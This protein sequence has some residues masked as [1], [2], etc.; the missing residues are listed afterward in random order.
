[1][2][3]QAMAAGASVLVLVVAGC[4]S[5]GG[6][7]ATGEAGANRAQDAS[8]AFARCMREHGVDMPDPRANGQSGDFSFQVPRNSKGNPSFERAQAACQHLMDRAVKAAGPAPDR[9]R[10]LNAALAYARCMRQHGLD[11]PDPKADPNGMVKIGG[12]G[13]N[14][15]D[16]AF[17]RADA[18]C[19][20]L[21]PGGGSGPSPAPAPGGAGAGGPAQGGP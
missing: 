7:G 17:K 3:R 20:R 10:L 1:M 14:P 12:G 21:L 2:T 15:D 16:P 19:R 8:V 11:F 18:S 9:D 5:G 6:E 13:T 4:G